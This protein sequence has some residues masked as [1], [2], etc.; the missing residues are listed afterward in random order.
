MKNYAYRN[1]SRFSDAIDRA[2]E[3]AGNRAVNSILDVGFGNIDELDA[4]GKVFPGAKI[5]A[6]D[7]D[8]RAIKVGYANAAK[9]TLKNISFRECD[10]NLLASSDVSLVDLVVCRHPDIDAAGANWGIAIPFIVG[11][12][13]SPSI[14]FFSTYNLSELTSIQTFIGSACIT[15]IPGAPYSTTPVGLNGSDRQMGAY[16]KVTY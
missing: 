4:L 1:L 16:V 9:L 10:A 7:S 8:A 2:V 11:L 3:R 15:K 13:R 14:F 12:M 6:V 5:L